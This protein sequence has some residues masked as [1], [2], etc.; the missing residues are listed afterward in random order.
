MITTTAITRGP[1]LTTRSTLLLHPLPASTQARDS[2]PNLNVPLRRSTLR[3]RHRATAP[4]AVSRALIPAAHKA[5]L[6][7]PTAARKTVVSA[8]IIS[9]REALTLIL[10]YVVCDFAS[11]L[12]VECYL[13]AKSRQVAEAT[14]VAQALYEH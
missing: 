11:L 6:T 14:L 9:R 3:L 4:A 10:L 12:N 5:A 2:G 8:V 13:V 1:G 7:T